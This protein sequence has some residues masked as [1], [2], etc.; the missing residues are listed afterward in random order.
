MTKSLPKSTLI[1]GTRTSNLARWQ[2]ARVIDLLQ[3]AWPGLNCESRP[4]QT[5]GD[6]ILDKPLPQ[7]GGKGLFTAELERALIE[8][9]IDLAVHSLKDLP[10]DDTPGLTIGAISDRADARDGLV[11]RHGWTLATLPE[12]ALVGTS[13]VRR[14][15]QLLARRP[16]LHVTSIR[17][18]V[19]TRLR[20]VLAD[21]LYDATVLA[22][23][24]LERLGLTEHVTEWLDWET[25]LPAPGQG[26]LAVQCRAQD[27]ATLTLLAALDDAAVRTAVTAERTFLNV[28]ESGCSAPVGAL[29][30]VAGQTITMQ[31]LVA[32]PSGQ[33]LIRV[34][35]QGPDPQ[36]LG[37]T[38]AQQ[39]MQQGAGHILARLQA[40]LPL[41]GRRIVVTRPLDQA[42]SFHDMLV[43]AFGRLIEELGGEVLLNAPVEKIL[44]ED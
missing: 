31:A 24:G 15:A 30:T 25:M 43:A 3:A 33:H 38:L 44:V 13:S 2:T 7:I 27:S 20:K 26:A 22:A 29:A 32:A 17:G 5:Q 11:A 35:G 23:A 9:S 42:R 6:K 14:Q 36:Q 1:L 12:G 37:Q 19:E 39:A 40:G 8:G 21:H 18:N 28:L 10:T 4:F 41:R 34:Q 16:D